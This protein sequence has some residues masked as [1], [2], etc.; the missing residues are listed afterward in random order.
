MEDLTKLCFSCMR[1]K[2]A[3]PVCPHCGSE[4]N[5]KQ[6]FPALPLGSLVGGRYYI[7]RVTKKNSEGITYL[8]YDIKEDLTCSV[9][10]FFPESL[11]VRDEDMVTIYSAPGSEQAYAECRESFNEMW[12]K[13]MRLKGL[14]ALINVTDVFG[15]GNTSYAVYAETEE[16]T[17][18]DYL[19]DTAQGYLEWEQARIL[20]MPVLSTL[21]T[22]HT[23]GVIH[24]G[25]NPD[26]FIFTSEGKLKLTDF[27][28]PQVRLAYRELEADIRDGYAPL[29]VYKEDG[30]VGSWTDIYSFCAVLYRT[31][32]GTT[33]ISAPVRAQNDQ[34]MIPAKFAE[35]LPPY[36]INALINGMQIN[37][38]DR[39]RNVEQLRSNLSASPRAVGASASIY[40]SH[41]VLNLPT[42]ELRTAPG[43]VAPD[44]VRKRAPRPMQASPQ[45]QR[46]TQPY[47]NGESRPVNAAQKQEKLSLNAEAAYAE[48]QMKEKKRKRLTLLLVLVIITLLAGVAL[49]V[50][51][52]LGGGGFGGDDEPASTQLQMLTVPDFVNQQFDAVAADAYY[53]QNLRLIKVEENDPTIPS[54]QIIYQSIAAGTTVT[55]GTE[56]LLTVSSGPRSF[57]IPD[58]TGLTYESALATLAAQGLVCV[59]ASKYN[60]GTHTPDTVAETVPP[61]NTKVTQGDTVQVV[62]WSSFVA[63]NSTSGADTSTAQ[64]PQNTTAP[65]QQPT[66]A[67]NPQN[68]TAPTQPGSESQTQN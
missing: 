62:M 39:T 19:L 5:P 11:A 64:N 68:T 63:E 35:K 33:P 30:A 20:F 4:A 49:V 34:M 7:G 6:E 48:Q 25:I 41:S 52:L 23:S 53:S 60:D 46:R 16:E 28:I 22:L 8:A 24:K 21:G 66:S 2:G 36:V 13:L 14:T 54:G 43:T 38:D 40:K 17:L 50:S 55:K 65:E 29:E 58:V 12:K 18:R 10:E 47:D 15:A 59:K 1:M 57:E 32:I 9:R 67:N 56:I 51:A 27:C 26:A 44:G 31:L 61:A 37:A 42:G 45:P 3:G